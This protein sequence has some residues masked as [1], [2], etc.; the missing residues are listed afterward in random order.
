MRSAKRTRVASGNMPD[1]KMK[2]VLVNNM[3]LHASAVCAACRQRLESDYL[4]DLSTLN[5]YC[6]PECRARRIQVDRPESLSTDNPFVLTFAWLALTLE[7]ASALLDRAAPHHE[8]P[9][10]DTA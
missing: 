6:G 10:S 1:R 3:A 9:G 4:R 2:F 8:I 5:R 7:V